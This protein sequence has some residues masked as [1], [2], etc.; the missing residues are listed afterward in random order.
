MPKKKEEEEERKKLSRG[1]R[2]DGLGS[3]ARTSLLLRTERKGRT[4]V[5][6]A[7]LSPLLITVWLRQS[8]V[9]AVGVM[10]CRGGGGKPPPSSF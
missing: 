3:E 2:P 8:S 6:I 4:E 10:V 5:V 9:V 7:R 1:R